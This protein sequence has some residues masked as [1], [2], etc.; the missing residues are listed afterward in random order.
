M[1]RRRVGSELLR[2]GLVASEDEAAALIESRRIRVNGVTV[3]NLARQ[4]APADAV[5]I[6]GPPARFVSRGGEKLDAALERF[7]IDVEGR[8]AIDVGSS[9]GG[10]TDC[11]LSRGA[12][13]VLSL[14]AGTNQ[15]HERLR[16]DP[17]VRVMEQ[18][19]V[20]HVD[21][22]TLGE[23]SFGVLSADLSFI[24]LR[25]LASG[26]V[27]LVEPGGDLV[28]LIK[29]QFEATH[30]EASKGRGVIR[31][32]AIWLETVSAVL[33][34]TES[35]GAATMGLMVSPLRGGSGNVEFL[36]HSRVGAPSTDFGQL[37]ADAVASVDG[38]S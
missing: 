21:L 38:E 31:D 13:S 15:L 2:R 9:T 34:A 18:T 35:A 24:S 20:R 8:R 22:E 27:S 30:D 1:A 28:L 33:S 16:A 5:V 19:N 37:V 29:P 12:A 25:G 4:V 14:D 17:R 36:A 10:F 6:E 7:E 23:E 11:L 32:P 3:D 26:L